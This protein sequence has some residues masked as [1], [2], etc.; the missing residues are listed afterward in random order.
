MKKYCKQDYIVKVGNPPSKQ[1]SV[2]TAKGGHKPSKDDRVKFSYTDEPPTNIKPKKSRKLKAI[3]FGESNHEENLDEGLGDLL[4]AFVRGLGFKGGVYGQFADFVDPKIGQINKIKIERILRTPL[5]IAEKYLIN[6]DLM[7]EDEIREYRRLST[8]FNVYG[9]TATSPEE[10]PPELLPGAYNQLKDMESKL[11]DIGGLEDKYE[12][13]IAHAEEALGLP[14]GSGR[15]DSEVG[16]YGRYGGYTRY[17]SRRYPTGYSRPEK[18]SL[19]KEKDI[20]DE[21]EDYKLSPEEIEAATKQKLLIVLESY[22]GSNG[23]LHQA[24]AFL[25]ALIPYINSTY[26]AKTK[27]QSD[28]T[29][30]QSS[31]RG[32]IKELNKIQNQAESLKASDLKGKLNAYLGRVR[33]AMSR[34][35]DLQDTTRETYGDEPGFPKEILNL[36]FVWTN[37]R[38][39]A[40][41]TGEEKVD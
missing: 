10:L 26:P 4:T 19:R 40:E 28:L 37:P 32:Y 5:T 31:I 8:I 23:M 25:D 17:G 22:I 34:M 27:L 3:I 38:T 1:A 30:R 33:P 2:L 15:F 20:E 13:A 9:H 7:S 12:S 29:R 36:P 6:Q 35:R 14:P 16:R 39:G 18:T 11:Y 21:E 24:N 41:L